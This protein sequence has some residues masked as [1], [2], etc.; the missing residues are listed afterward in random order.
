M[1]LSHR[2]RLSI[3]LSSVADQ[4]GVWTFDL[5]DDGMTCYAHMRNKKTSQT[6]AQ[7]SPS[8]CPPVAEVGCI[9]VDWVIEVALALVN[10]TLILIA[11]LALLTHV[12]LSLQIK[13]ETGKVVGETDAVSYKGL[14]S[15]AEKVDVPVALAS[16][17]EFLRK[18]E[19][20]CG[21][22]EVWLAR[23]HTEIEQRK[24]TLGVRTGTC[25]T[26]K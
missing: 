9:Q 2:W 10:S 17:R 1:S 13:D 4:G 22:R 25:A 6:H 12:T 7:R 15:L 3:L 14:L 8:R 24:T 20:G 23:A 16:Y 21:P 26:S 5:Y 18:S 19:L 11:K